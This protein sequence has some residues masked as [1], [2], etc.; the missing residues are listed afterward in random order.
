LLHTEHEEDWKFTIKQSD[1]QQFND[2]GIYPKKLS[3]DDHGAIKIQGLHSEHWWI[4]WSIRFPHVGF[5]RWL[6]G[7]SQPFFLTAK[8]NGVQQRYCQDMTSS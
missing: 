3:I 6:D 1:K 4:P 7:E 5:K 2:I 8:H